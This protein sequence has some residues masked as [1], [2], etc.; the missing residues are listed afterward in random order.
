MVNYLS[1]KSGNQMSEENKME[2]ERLRKLI[3]KY[4]TMENNKE[5][6]NTNNETKKDTAE[7]TKYIKDLNNKIEEVDNENEE[8]EY[9]EVEE[10]IE[11]T[12]EVEVDDDKNQ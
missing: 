3:K 5:N 7:K 11:V 9:E 1:K 2:L 8:G 10:E 4:E 6:N 12:E